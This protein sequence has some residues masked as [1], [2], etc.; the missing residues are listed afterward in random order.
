MKKLSLILL[1]AFVCVACAKKAEKTDTVSAEEPVVE[2]VVVE[3]TIAEEPIIEEAAEEIL[4]EEINVI[5][6]STRIT[7]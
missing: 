5:D 6:Y 1:A 2:E 3:E 7:Y 4:A